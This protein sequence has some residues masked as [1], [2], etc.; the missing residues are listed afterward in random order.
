MVIDDIPGQI[1]TPCDV[2]GE[3][4]FSGLN[5]CPVC[6]S[7]D[8]HWRGQDELDVTS[9]THTQTTGEHEHEPPP[10]EFSAEEEAYSAIPAGP[11]SVSIE[12]IKLGGC[13]NLFMGVMTLGVANLAIWLSTRKWPVLADD[14]G[15]VLG[16]GKRIPWEKIQRVEHITTSVDGTIAHKFTFILDS[17]T[18]TL[19]YERLVTPQPVLDFVMAR[20]PPSAKQSDT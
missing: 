15:V 7:P 3:C 14:S 12:Y 5:Q 4:D 16:N 8:V 6:A 9:P 2:C 1:T 18:W 20:V 11:E 13:L 17:G 19:P 10:A